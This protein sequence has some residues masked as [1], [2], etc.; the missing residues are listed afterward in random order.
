MLNICIQTGVLRKMENVRESSL[1]FFMKFVS[2]VLSLFM[3]E[4][5][6]FIHNHLIS[7]ATDTLLADVASHK[8]HFCAPDFNFF[9]LGQSLL[10]INFKKKSHFITKCN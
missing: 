9:F 3:P 10:T 4:S 5:P 8:E 7:S 6:S 1:S 2:V